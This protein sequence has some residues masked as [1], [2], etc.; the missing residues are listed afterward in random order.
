MPWLNKPLV[1]LVIVLVTL[2]VPAS[3]RGADVDELKTVVEQL[4]GA[5][6]NKNL[7]AWSPSV[8]DQAV[9][10][11]LISPFPA[12][13]KAALRQGFQGLFAS[14]ESFTIVPLN[15]QYRVVGAS[16][17]AWGHVM[18]TF[19]PK[20]GPTRMLW[21]R[22]IMTWTKVGGKWQMLTVHASPIPV[23]GL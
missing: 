17:Y 8:H 3:G 7:D 13:S 22:E 9:G 19:K 11:G 12:D 18:V 5:L 23:N 1:S 14:M 16:G 15:W 20:E 4:I 10:F 6:N 2:S 21:G